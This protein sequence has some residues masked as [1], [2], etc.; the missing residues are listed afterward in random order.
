[1]TIRALLLAAAAV[2]LFAA[3]ALAQQP[4][5]EGQREDETPTLTTDDVAPA[6]I[7]GQPAGAQ[8]AAP[9][10]GDDA[11]LTPEER[12]DAASAK[13]AG[14]GEAGKAP[15]KK[16]GPSREELAWR[17]RYAQAESQMRAARQRA[18]EAELQ[19]T[20]M[21]NRL[22]STGTVGER[23]ALAADIETQ[24]DVV[25][26]AQRAA[27]DAEAAF[28]AIRAEGESKKFT[29]DSG[30]APTTK[31]GQTNDEYYRQRVSKAQ[32]DVADAERRLKI[33]QDRVN[34]VRGRILNNSGSGDQFSGYRLQEELDAALKE[35]DRAQVDRDKARNALDAATQEAAAAGV[36]IR[37]Y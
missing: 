28:E 14:K 34:D 13:S 33:Y 15:D 11:S 31:D 32:S 8:T 17:G 9:A 5:P 10:E 25:R 7:V 21:Q 12:A 23:N 27:A 36:S 26:Q 35:L 37:P 30:P 18:Q 22:G 20:D 6:P 2:A 16:K 19:L 4:A 24:G 3:P 29:P 1:M